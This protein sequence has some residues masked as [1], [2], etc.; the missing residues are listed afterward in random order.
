M[1]KVAALAE[2]HYVPIAPHCTM[3]YLGTSASLHVA[4]SVPMFLI[5][6]GNKKRLP[7]DVAIKQWEMDEDGYVSLPEGPG[8]GVEVNEARAIEVGQTTE[9]QFKWPNARLRDGAVSDY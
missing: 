9:Q 2:A 6:E 1:R 3:T 7:E 4:A 8:L 5:H